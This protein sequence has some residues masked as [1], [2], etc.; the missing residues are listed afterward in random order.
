MPQT[1]PTQEQLL[2]QYLQ[3]LSNQNADTDVTTDSDNAIRGNATANVVGGLY[4][5]MAW[6]LRQ[7]FPDTADSDYLDIHA[8][9]RGLHRKQP[10]AASGSVTLTG[11]AGTAFA[12]KLQFRVAGSDALYQTLAGGTLDNAGQATV[13]ASALT[14]GA[15]GNLT[16]DVTGTLVTAP[17]GLDAALTVVSMVGGTDIE[18]D[19]ALLARLLDILRK[20]AAGGNAHDYKV[21]AMDVDGVGNAWVYPLRRG[22]GTVD[23]LIT[24][25][26]G[27]PADSTV[28]AVQAYIDQRRPVTAKDCRVLA[29]ADRTV[30]IAVAVAFSQDTTLAAV[31]ADVKT[32]VSGYFA[33]LLPG[34][35]AVR[36][37]L[38]ALITEVP[39]LTDYS[40]THPASN[41]TPVVDEATVEWL[42]MGT[43]TV[44]TMSGAA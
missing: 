4:H 43:V 31:T 17:T 27:L 2:A 12:G 10:T 37:Q 25:T 21:W 14:L 20:P 38:G 35:I 36:S 6:V 39:G 24:G 22:L 41:V 3:A 5:M 19:S 23:V 26:E 29:P 16:G 7:M 33:S 28:K 13:P 34:Q 8:A 18:R 32:A 15:A 44:T 30:D 42:R 9:Q 11:A 40:I 1:I